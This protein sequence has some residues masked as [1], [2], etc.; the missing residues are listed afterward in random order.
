MEYLF[1]HALTQV[2]YGTIAPDHRRA[3]QSARH[4]RL[5]SY[6]FTLE[7]HYS[8]LAITTVT[9]NAPKAVQYI[10]LAGQQTAQRSAN[11]KR[12]RC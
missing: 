3:L 1:K 5:K 11:P 7:E 4:K 9:E 6:H 12:W 8:E 2:A 10:Q